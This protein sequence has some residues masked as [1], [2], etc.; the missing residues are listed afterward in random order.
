[1]YT[2]TFMPRLV[3][4]G[5]SERNFIS[6][7]LLAKS[8]KMISGS[9]QHLH[10]LIDSHSGLVMV[11]LPSLTLCS[12]LPQSVSSGSIAAIFLLCCHDY[13]TTPPPQIKLHVDAE[14]Y[15]LCQKKLMEFNLSK[16]PG[17]RWCTNVSG[18]WTSRAGLQP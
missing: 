13:V 15:H 3:V 9:C 7:D 17:F 2:C 4:L 16:E 1:M 18:R 10:G 8:V 14:M 12:C 11:T 5:S 6:A